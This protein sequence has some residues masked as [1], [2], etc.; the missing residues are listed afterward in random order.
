MFRFNPQNCAFYPYSLK[1]SYI[2]SGDWPDDG[3]DV[4]FE[5]FKQ[6]KL[7]LPPS[8]MSIGVDVDGNPTW[9]PTQEKPTADPTPIVQ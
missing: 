5:T 2:E 3:I 4:E 7:D 6:F 8:D 1:G 9:V